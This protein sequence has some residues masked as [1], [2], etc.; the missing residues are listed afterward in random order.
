MINLRKKSKSFLGKEQGS[1]WNGIRCQY[2]KLNEQEQGSMWLIFTRFVSSKNN[3]YANCFC[4]GWMLKFIRH[5]FVRDTQFCANDCSMDQGVLY[6]LRK[7]LLIGL[8]LCTQWWIKLL[9]FVVE[10]NEIETS[11]E[12]DW[13][14]P[15]CGW[16]YE[17]FI[18]ICFWT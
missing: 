2:F 17:K 11:K 13:T 6:L 12:L 4:W 10:I 1:L 5:F 18:K 15:F 14:Y 16:I 9:Y 8:P 3:Q 7:Y